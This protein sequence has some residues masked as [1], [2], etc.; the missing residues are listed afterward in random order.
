MF[1]DPRHQV[2][3][4]STF[5][6]LVEERR[7][8]MQALLE[9]D[10]IPAG[11]EL[12]PASDDDSWT[13]IKHVID[14]SDYYIV[15]VGGRYGSVHED[16][17]SYTRMEYEYALES[18]KPIMGFLHEDPQSLPLSRSEE[19]EAG[20]AALASF[21]EL[22]AQKQCK[23]WKTPED[24]GGAVSRG[25]VRL[26]RSHPMAGW[27]RADTH[28]DVALRERIM[29][30]ET[31]LAALRSRIGR[32]SIS[33]NSTLEGGDEKVTL[34]VNPGRKSS[35]VQVTWNEVFRAMT[36]SALHGVTRDELVQFLGGWL[37]RRNKVDPPRY[38]GEESLAQ[39]LIFMIASGVLE[40]QGKTYYL[41]ERGIGLAASMQLKGKPAEPH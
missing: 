8:V 14:E 11:M 10:C 37:G 39:V 40:R 24:L 26:R 28:G 31:E 3:V 9:L 22:V 6:D 19:S 35:G 23:F 2:F 33:R 7:H 16:G 13:L 41:T 32:R 20:R 17:I 25:M 5:S 30:L 15:I 36:P 21:R 1:S 4:S 12:F 27:V 38:L 34:T 18:R 29:E